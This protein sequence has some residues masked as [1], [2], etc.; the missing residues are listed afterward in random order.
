MVAIIVTAIIVTE[1]AATIAVGAT[2]AVR[3]TKVIAATGVS[4]ATHEILATINAEKCD[5]Q[6]SYLTIRLPWQIGRR[7]R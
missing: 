3:A 4:T 1:T 6:A 2:I 5:I 7:W